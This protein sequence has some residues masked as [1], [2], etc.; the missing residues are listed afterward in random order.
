MIVYRHQN[1]GQ[2]ENSTIANNF[3]ENVAEFKYL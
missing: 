3:V 2:N 1:T